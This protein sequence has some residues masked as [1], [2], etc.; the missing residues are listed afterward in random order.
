[1]VVR[2]L[3]LRCVRTEV[4]SAKSKDSVLKEPALP[5]DK[6]KTKRDRDGVGWK[7]GPNAS[8][9]AGRDQNGRR[10]QPYHDTSPAL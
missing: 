6:K 4:G 8:Q 9:V 1:M 5:A 2:K 7:A 10:A 3:E